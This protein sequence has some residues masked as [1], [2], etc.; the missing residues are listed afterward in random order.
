MLQKLSEHI[1]DCFERAARAEERAAEA[2]NAA[3]KEDH[4]QIAKAW[5]HL[6]ASYQ[7]VE[8]LERSSSTWTARST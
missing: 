4:E 5:R 6:A 2:S 7:F 3:A 8:A 1:S